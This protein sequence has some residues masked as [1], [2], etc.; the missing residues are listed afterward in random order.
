M[1]NTCRVFFLVVPLL[2]S[3][4]LALGLAPSDS[5]KLR[6]D[7]YFF[8][9]G[10]MYDLHAFQHARMLHKFTDAHERVPAEVLKEH[11]A[12]IRANVAAAEKSFAHLSQQTQSKPS[13]AAK[14]TEIRTYNRKILKV[15]DQVEQA[16]RDQKLEAQTL[17]QQAAQIKQHLTASYQTSQS[18]ASAEN[19]FTE[20][21]DQPG[22]GVFSD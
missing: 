6:G 18:A 13:M 11:I 17:Q 21:W 3:V 10:Q 4:S 1:K 14:L 12:A 8:S 22:H 7:S 9:M 20:Q 5:P 2:I 16:A 19:I 15:C